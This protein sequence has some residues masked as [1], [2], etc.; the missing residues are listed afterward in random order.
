MSIEENLRRARDFK[1]AKV[2][3]SGVRFDVD[4]PYSFELQQ[5]ANSL[6]KT[7]ISDEIKFSSLDPKENSSGR[8][9]PRAEKP[10]KDYLSRNYRHYIQFK[11]RPYD[12]YA[13][14]PVDDTLNRLNFSD[15]SE[16]EDWNDEYGF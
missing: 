8:T 6:V 2:R 9:K 10:V 3:N 11:A 14:D 13:S 4:E 1:K 7:S 16:G 15:Q 12:G 5:A